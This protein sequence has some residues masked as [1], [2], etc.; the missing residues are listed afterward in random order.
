MIFLLTVPLT[1]HLTSPTIAFSPELSWYSCRGQNW[2]IRYIESCHARTGK[3]YTFHDQ[4]KLGPNTYFH[5]SCD[6][7]RP[8]KLC[9]LQVCFNK[10]LLSFFVGFRAADSRLLILNDWESQ[11]KACVRFLT[12]S[13]GTCLTN[14]DFLSR[15]SSGGCEEGL[16]TFHGGL[17]RKKIYFLIL[18]CQ[19]PDQT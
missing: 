5:W 1:G 13:A 18:F 7:E 4:T 16:T 10:T 17:L 19:F 12:S 14:K 11:Q 2:P 15:R 9:A 3:N 8:L 6:L